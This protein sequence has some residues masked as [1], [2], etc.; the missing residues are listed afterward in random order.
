LRLLR[1]LLLLLLLLLRLLLL[2]LLLLL[3]LMNGFLDMTSNYV[4]MCDMVLTGFVHKHFLNIL[5][6]ILETI[7]AII[8]IRSLWIWQASGRKATATAPTPCCC[9]TPCRSACGHWNNL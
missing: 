2:L 3:R 7:V 9:S 4:T 6:T 1:L 5:K 8:S